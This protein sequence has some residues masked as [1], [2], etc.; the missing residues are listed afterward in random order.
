[1][2]GGEVSLGRFREIANGDAVLVREVVESVEHGA[3]ERLAAVEADPD[4]CDFTLAT[5]A[6]HTPVG[7]S[8]NMGACLESVAAAMGRAAHQP[9][10]APH[11]PLD[12]TSIKRR[13]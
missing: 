5:R 1:M 6:A 12:A 13:C 10:A 2:Q 11:C 9:D 8:A 3:R 7:A 4:R